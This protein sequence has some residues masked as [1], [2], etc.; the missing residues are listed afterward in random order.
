MGDMVQVI[1][2]IMFWKENGC[3][4]SKSSYQ[5]RQ[6]GIADIGLKRLKKQTR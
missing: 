3:L 1:L 4:S 6:A 5:Q 2:G